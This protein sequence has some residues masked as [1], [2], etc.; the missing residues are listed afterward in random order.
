MDLG[1]AGPLARSA[2]DLA[3]ALNVLGGPSGDDA[4][5]WE[6][7]MPAPRQKR[8]KDFRIGYLIDDKF[9]PVA[10]DIREVYENVLG[11]L[12]RTAAKME[13]GWPAGI[14]PQAQLKTYQYLLFAFLSFDLEKE[15]RESLRARLE[16]NPD[17]IYAAAAVEP[18]GRWL[19]ETQRRLAFR[20][21][22][23]KYFESHDVFLLPAGFSAA[24]PHDHSQ[25]LEKR[26]IETP[27]GKRPYIETPLWTCFAALAGLPATVAPVG[28]TKARLPAGIQIVAPM[29]EDGTS[30]EFAALL[31]E[32]TGSFTAPEGFR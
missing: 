1:A 17:D 21:I 2:R 10:S 3:L 11:E 20:A 8:L 9:C 18:H 30:I 12:T 13:S 24:F 5:A 14:D 16:K 26:V 23:Q 31:T 27:E 25:P 22:W 15:Q 32:I 19:I 4:K 7:H 6:W 28:R 29:W